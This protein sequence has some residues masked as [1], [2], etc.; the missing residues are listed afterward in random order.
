MLGGKSDISP[1][2]NSSSNYAGFTDHY[3]TGS[4]NNYIRYTPRSLNYVD[5]AM[6]QWVHFSLYSGNIHDCKI[7]GT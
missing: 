1:N 2:T 5:D 4:L 3:S 6:R 7:Y